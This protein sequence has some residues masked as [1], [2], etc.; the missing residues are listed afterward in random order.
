M[1]YLNVNQ[2]KDGKKIYAMIVITLILEVVF[3][4]FGFKK[5]ETIKYSYK[6]NNLVDY[7]V[8]LK[9]NKYFDSSYIGKGKTYITSLIDYIN[10]DFT[11]NV[12]FNNNVTGDVNYKVIAQI[13]ADKDKSEIGNYWTKEYELTESK[14]NSIKNANSHSINVTQQIDYNTYN[15]L[16]YK[17][18]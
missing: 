2:T 3:S 1:R 7:K 6:E 5:C 17:R 14:T 4:F 12:D 10:A 13:K 9:E 11:Y 18:I 8:F 15:D 16:I